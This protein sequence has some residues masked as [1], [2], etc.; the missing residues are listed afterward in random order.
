MTGPGSGV[1]SCCPEDETASTS[2]FP[3]GYA[4]GK[5]P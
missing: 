2:I 1:S 4:F 3:G 5:Y